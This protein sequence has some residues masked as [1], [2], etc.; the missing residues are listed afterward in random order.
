MINIF[1]I[2]KK[3]RQAFTNPRIFLTNRGGVMNNFMPFFFTTSI[4]KAKV[5]VLFQDV[6]GN[7]LKYATEAKEN[8]IPIV[9]VQHGRGAADDY[10]PPINHKMLAD[11]VCVWGTRD[12]E[13]LTKGG[14]PPE[15]VALTGCPLFDGLKNERI[16]HKG[17]N[18]LFAPAHS[19]GDHAY[20]D[21]SNMEIMKTLRSL[22][23][24][25]ILVKLLSTH[26]DRKEYGRNIILS[27]SFDNDHIQKCIAAVRRSDLLISNQSGTIELIAM[28]FNLPVIFIKVPN[29]KINALLSIRFNTQ[30]PPQSKTKAFGAYF[31]DSA[32]MLP[33]A[34]DEIA[35]NPTMLDQSR[36]EE[37]LAAAGVGLPGSP[38]LKIIE[39][40]KGLAK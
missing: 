36:K 38:T 9:V 6:V 24:I 39:I 23:G 33:E 40:I 27:N 16:R 4:K 35:S 20:N 28:Y 21:P 19:I 2:I 29:P 1:S 14:Y 34:I 13:M 10:L 25:N 7:G 11:K 15:R 5:A 37:L 30:F 3:N 8:G 32:K 31:L 26:K 18:I 12:Y 22:K 17:T